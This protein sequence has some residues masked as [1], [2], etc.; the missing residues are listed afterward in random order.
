M[1]FKKSKDF[2]DAINKVSKEGVDIQIDL[3]PK[4]RAFYDEL[5]RW[6]E[7]NGK[8]FE[9]SGY[10]YLKNAEIEWYEDLNYLINQL[11]GK[12]INQLGPKEVV[13]RDGTKDRV[14]GFD[15]FEDIGDDGGY[16]QP[17]EEGIKW[18]ED[19]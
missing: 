16:P 14:T 13:L 1:K 5:I 12:E 3:Q 19:E 4:K 17:N 11:D 7:W 18:F 2:I 6:G 10:M 15:G 8:Y 9:I